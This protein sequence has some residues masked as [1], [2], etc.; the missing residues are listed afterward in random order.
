M[1]DVDYKERRDRIV[2]VYSPEQFLEDADAVNAQVGI[3]L[4]NAQESAGN[5]LNWENETEN[6]QSAGQ[7]LHDNCGISDLVGKVLAS[8]QTI[9]DPRYIGHQV[10]PPI[11]V[12]SLFEQVS[13]ITN[14][15]MTVYEMGPW[16]SSV[17]R[18]M[19]DILGTELGLSKGFGGIL[20]SGGSLANLTALLTARN[21]LL[22]SCWER[23][24]ASLSNTAIIFSSS[25][26][27]YSIDR[28]AGILG[29][30]SANN[31]KV[32]TDDLNRMDPASLEKCIITALSSDQL[33]I[34]VVASCCSTRT[35]AFDQLADISEIC[36]KYGVWL[37]VDAAHG[38]AVVFSEKYRHLI[39]SIELAD[40]ISL[41]AHKMLFMPALSTY[42]FYKNSPD[43]YLALN[44]NASYLFD[45]QDED[46]NSH[47]SD[48]GLGTIECTKRA[49][50]LSLWGTWAIYGRQLFTD[51]VDST[52]Y[53]AHRFAQLIAEHKDYD[54]LY[55]PEANI[56]LFRYL[57]PEVRILTMAQQGLFQERLRRAIIIGGE[58][59]IV[60]AKD[61]DYSCLRLV[62]MNPLTSEEH[63]L[64]LTKALEKTSNVLL[65][66]G[67]KF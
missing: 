61:D 12:S 30:G 22:S 63:F 14:Q 24:V 66:N 33:I 10:P 47:R 53:M 26:S 32:D 7:L 65:I 9:H 31:I 15:G 52:F 55:Q 4:R 59:Y 28:A 49:A 8:G 3:F 11:P 17:E 13:S 1:P 39:D 44:Q 64:Q 51:L 23:G 36:Q 42:L 18:T 6:V 29:L 25:E 45:E 58:F 5:V 34:A 20:T 21:K 35:G 16:A 41:D 48:T 46:E 19:I 67:G 50:A 27:H 38:G 2:K 62:V 60:G 37:H 43:Q 56:V 54:L 40:S 57:P